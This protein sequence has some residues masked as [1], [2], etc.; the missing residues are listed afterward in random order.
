MKYIY[1]DQSTISRLTN[2]NDSIHT[3]I[4]RLANHPDF[5]IILSFEHIIESSA[6][7]AFKKESIDHFLR[8]TR[9]VRLIGHPIILLIF[10]LEQ[11]AQKVLRRQLT[12]KMWNDILKE[13]PLDKEDFI[14]LSNTIQLDKL[15][16][17]SHQ[18]LILIWKQ[19]TQIYSNLYGKRFTR[20]EIAGLK[21]PLPKEFL[22]IMSK[23]GFDKDD[24]I[25]FISRISTPM[26]HGEWYEFA[27]INAFLGNS[28]T[29]NEIELVYEKWSAE[30][31][32][33]PAL[34]FYA[35]M[36]KKHGVPQSGSFSDIIHLIM[37]EF[38]DYMITDKPNINYLKSQLTDDHWKLYLSKLITNE[39]IEN[40]W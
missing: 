30:K 20:N 36:F 29:Q 7:G 32:L 6:L 25:N 14:S 39:D 11:C 5:L 22:E 21:E 3:Y 13:D 23:S 33:C 12:T 10:S 31:H 27:I 24:S 37:L 1:F 8:K 28:L 17:D 38:V 35:L 4:A 34:T 18:K 16:K 26:Q 15:Y 19:I 9:N 40:I 2:I